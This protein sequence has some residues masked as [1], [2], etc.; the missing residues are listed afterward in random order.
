MQ[1]LNVRHFYPYKSNT[2]ERYLDNVGNRDSV[3]HVNRYLYAVSRTYRA[4]H[5]WV[6]KVQDR[7]LEALGEAGGDA[8]MDVLLA[9]ER[10][11]ART[12][13]V[14]YERAKRS[15]AKGVSR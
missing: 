12:G 1:H 7:R 6:E 4:L 5:E 13:P 15:L 3:F 8:Y 9:V 14:D 10:G 11:P 2:W